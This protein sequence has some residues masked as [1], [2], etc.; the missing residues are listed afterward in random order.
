MPKRYYEKDGNLDYLNGRTVAIIGYGS[1]GHAHALN[2]R[3]S[4]VDVVVGLYPGSKS[5][6]KAEAAGL[7]VMTAG[8][9][10]KAAN[11]V[12]ILVSDHIQADLYN[13]DIAPHMTEGKTLMFAHGFNIHFKQIAPPANVDVSMIA[14]KAPGHRVRELFTEGVGVPA[15]VAVHQNPSGQATERA[16]AY[17]LALG[18]LKAGVIET[19][20]REETESDLFGEQAV[21]CGGAAELVRA[22]FETLVA[23]GYAPEIAYFECLHELKL[24]VDLIQEGGLSYMRYSVSDTAEYGDYTRGPRVVNDQTRAE[25]KKILSE[26]QSGEFARQWIDENKTGRHKFLAMRAAA[27][28]QPIEKVG[29]ELREMMTFL[30]KKKEVGVPVG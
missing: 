21:L 23:A 2:L 15:L 6:S 11:V 13:K 5:W 1:Q 25:M 17:A 4:G 20:F 29:R 7:K 8:D 30:K 3:D 9:A 12:M 16:L 22:G 19:D 28:D 26:I 14:P 18:C 24:I 10:A 27:Q